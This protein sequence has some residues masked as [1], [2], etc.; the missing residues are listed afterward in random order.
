M[1]D[2]LVV[3]VASGGSPVVVNAIHEHPTCQCFFTVDLGTYAIRS[4]E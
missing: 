1:T 3:V 4:P 2:P